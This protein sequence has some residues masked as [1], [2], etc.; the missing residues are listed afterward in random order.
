MIAKFSPYPAYRPS[1]VDMIGELPSHWDLKPLKALAFVRPSNVDKKIEAGEQIVRLCGYTDVYNSDRITADIDFKAGSASLEEVAKF[2]LRH[3]DV[4]L[5]KDSETANDIG[6]P[7]LVDYEAPDLVCGYHLAIV[8]AR[9]AVAAGS[10]LFWAIKSRPL[11]AQFEFNAQGVTRFGLS[12]GAMGGVATPTPPLSEQCAIA[13]FLD[14]ETAK[15]DALIE[16]KRRIIELLEE[17]R[18]T[19]L[20][21]LVTK[22]LDHTAP[23]KFSGADWL[24]DIPVPWKVTPLKW[25]ATFVGGATPSKDRL[26]FWTGDIPWVSPK[27]MKVFHI[28]DT[29][30]HLSPAAIGGS[31]LNWI[32]PLSVLIVVRGLILARTVPIAINC[33]SV[34]INQDMKA[35]VCGTELNPIFLAY[36]LRSATQKLLSI[37]EETGHGTKALRTD[38]LSAFDICVPPLSEQLS[39]AAE[40]Q[41]IEQKISMTVVGCEKIIALLQESGGP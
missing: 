10:F 38:L 14:R 41:R 31:S 12:V 27:D 33:R 37:T 34:T 5:T 18:K 25:I 13:A 1:G 6:V 17:K 30:D 11:Q 3:G 39:I 7:A 15:I 20:A 16:K 23:M 19:V 2:R 29:I 26:D 32:P 40:C 35:I 21:R 22:G 4:V 24:G 9:P 36:F 8:R 28:E